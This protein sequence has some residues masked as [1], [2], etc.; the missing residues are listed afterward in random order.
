MDN[1]VKKIKRARV[2]RTPVTVLSPAQATALIESASFE[3]RP[4]FLIAL[5]AGLRPQ[6]EMLLLDWKDIDRKYGRI[7][8]SPSEGKETGGRFVPIED[9]LAKWLEPYAGCKEGAVIS[10]I[11]FRRRFEASRK[12]ADAWLKENDLED[13]AT[14]TEEWGQDCTR[15]SYATYWGGKHGDIARCAFHLG[16]SEA[17]HRK[18]YHKPVLTPEAEAYWSIEPDGVSKI[19]RM[20][21]A[22]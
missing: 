12:E 20:K 13:E 21:E 7:W 14:L 10:S 16:H 19:V 1:P 4:Y 22:G 2:T 3:F 9:N 17:V 8:V 15:H 11:N 5:F 18:H 6:S